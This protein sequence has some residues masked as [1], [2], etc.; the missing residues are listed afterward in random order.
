M[1]ITRKLT[2]IIFSILLL[3]G[4][5]SAQYQADANNQ[6]GVENQ[7]DAL[8]Q[9][10]VQNPTPIPS[11]TNLPTPTPLPSPDLTVCA[12][13]CDF[14]SIQAA[15]D[16]DTTSAGAIIGLLDSIHT[17]AG[18][19]IG[20]SITIQGNGATETIVQA[21]AN[22]EEAENRVFE[23]LS[24]T[25]VTLRGMTIQH[26]QPTTSPMTGG[27]IL[28]YGTL[29]TEDVIVQK[30]YGSAGGGI[31]NEGTLTMLNS[32][33][34]ENGSVGGGDK[35]LECETG[36]GLKILTGQVTLI[37]SII[38]NNKSNSKGG[39]VHVACYGYLVLVNSTVSGNYADESGGGIYMNGSGNF[40]HS[41]IS[42]NSANNIG[43]VALNGKDT[44]DNMGQLSLSYTIIAGNIARMDK[45]GIADC[46]MENHAALV[47]NN[48][49]WIGDG[50]CSPD[51]SGDP[52]LGPLQDNG[53][54]T[55]THSLLP[56]SPALDVV[57]A[58]S[59]SVETDQRG[60]PRLGPCDLGAFEVQP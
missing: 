37:N 24:D 32:T 21:H 8:N 40:T 35:Y 5:V 33:I 20:K 19:K 18:I 57:S 26:G 7:T 56:G 39:G 1:N 43:G 51:F 13:G 44:V 60:E 2:I 28:N 16:A 47:E 22:P 9:A 17:E 14:N 11:P 50:S 45:H 29:T 46:D 36:G 30:N 58:E 48:L 54:L 53:G 27:G 4:C 15:I 12:S 49:N 10:S 52:L 42:N 6:A 23:V 38:S 41:T 59:C 31:Y 3:G 34:T 25:T 55:Q